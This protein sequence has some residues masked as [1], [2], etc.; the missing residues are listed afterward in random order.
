[1]AG[2]STRFSKLQTESYLKHHKF[3]K[4]HCIIDNIV[5][6]IYKNHFRNCVMMITRI[7]ADLQNLFNEL[8]PLMR[9]QILVAI[10]TEFRYCNDAPNLIEDQEVDIAD[11]Q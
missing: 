7:S 2:E 9:I 1:M 5:F 4:S 8:I 6:T 11:L 3:W 10:V